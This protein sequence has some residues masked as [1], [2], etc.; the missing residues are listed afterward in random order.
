MTVLGCFK[1]LNLLLLIRVNNRI[2]NFQYLISNVINPSE[3]YFTFQP[4]ELCSNPGTVIPAKA[5][6]QPF[7]SDVELNTM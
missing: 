1:M 2:F 3:K 6:I 5:G 7:L 4:Y